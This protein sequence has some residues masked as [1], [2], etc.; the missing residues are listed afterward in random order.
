MNAR[1]RIA[2]LATLA[3]FFLAIVL[4]ARLAA[5]RIA[6]PF[7]GLE[8]FARAPRAAAR[9]AEPDYDEFMR[10]ID[11]DAPAAAPPPKASVRAANRARPRLERTTAA[12]AFLRA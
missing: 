10:R 9:P 1:F 5:R 7:D 8:Q 3:L 6:A 12:V 11:W 4:G 2:T